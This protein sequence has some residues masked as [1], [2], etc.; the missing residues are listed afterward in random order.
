MPF[1]IDSLTITQENELFGRDM[2]LDSS[3]SYLDLV[4]DSN[5]DIK[6]TNGLTNLVS[7]SAIFLLLTAFNHEEGRGELPFHPEFGSSFKFL[8]KNPLP[9]ND[10][11]DIIKSEI[12]TSLYKFYGDLIAGIS[13]SEVEFKSNGIIYFNIFIQTTNGGTIS[14]GMTI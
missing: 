10:Y 4:A 13:F 1:T 14:M 5:G 9:D 12:I 7:N 8:I 11:I 6:I 2:Q 3:D